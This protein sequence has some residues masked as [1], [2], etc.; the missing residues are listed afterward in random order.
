MSYTT[1]PSVDPGI[2][3]AAESLRSVIVANYKSIAETMINGA[4]KRAGI[5]PKLSAAALMQLTEKLIIPQIHGAEGGWSENPN[6]SGGPTMRGV[7]LSTLKGGFNDVFINTGIPQVATAAKAFNAKY[8]SW[9]TDLS[10]GK[11]FLYILCSDGKVGALF[12]YYFMS[13]DSGRSP[14]AVMSEDPWLG[15]IFLEG[16]WGSGGG[17][18]GAKRANLDAVAKEYGWKGSGFVKFICGLGDKTPE[19][20]NKMFLARLNFILRIS[21]PGLKNAV[22]RKG[23]LNRLI[24]NKDSNLMMLVKINELFN[25]NA[26]GHFQFTPQEKEHLKR[27]GEIYK[28]LSINIP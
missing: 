2:K 20:A 12:I 21:R 27:K 3:A 19:I 18:Y 4:F 24:N 23:W 25:L 11:Q 5:T 7:I 15:Y 26:K 17:I 13:N 6:D 14:V 22:F 16:V 9:K 28:T 10:V 8:G 1:P